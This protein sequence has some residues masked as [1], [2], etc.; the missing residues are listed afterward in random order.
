[1]QDHG[2]NVV[3]TTSRD[4]SPSALSPVEL[5]NGYVGAG[6][7]FALERCGVLDVLR[8]RDRVSHEELSLLTST[9]SDRLR[10]LLDAGV[11][12]RLIDRDGDC[13]SLTA[14]GLEL[15]RD[16]GYFVW[17]VGG[18]GGVI[19]SLGDWARGERNFGVDIR[20]DMVQVAAG[21]ARCDEAFMAPVLHRVLDEL[22]FRCVA[23]VGCGNATRLV[24]IC[25][26]YP[27]TLG[28]G[29]DLSPDTCRVARER[30]ELAGLSD[31]VRVC[32]G[33][34]TAFAGERELRE[35]VDL[36]CS[37]LLLHDLF[38]AMSPPE[39]LFA[40]LRETFPNANRYLF[41][42]TNATPLDGGEPTI[43]TAGYELVH[44]VMGV[45]IGTVDE[46]E[47]IMARAGLTL[48]R[49]LPLGVP[50]TWLYV[51]ATT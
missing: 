26:R 18:C 12:L 6:V 41:A 31:R 30:V 40:R 50:N 49:R 8:Q 43:F 48:E 22:D 11:R 28:L 3:L 2:A 32:Q 51:L 10:T 7:A 27:A 14:S 4:A 24:R 17:A 29:I 23:D 21:S 25:E 44:G 39:A 20:R 33:D 45:P 46:Y 15:A 38:A 16:A 36:V 13:L 5:F 42:D 47:R 1:M 35:Q 19:S 9:Q 37:F 34:A